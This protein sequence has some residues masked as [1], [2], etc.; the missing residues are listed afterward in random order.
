LS[1]VRNKWRADVGS[2]HHLVAAE[3]QLKIMPTGKHFE[4]TRNK[5]DVQKL[6]NKRKLAEFKL[7]LRNRCQVLTYFPETEIDTK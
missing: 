4:T 6:Q 2:D 5:G 7:E 3:F 1:N